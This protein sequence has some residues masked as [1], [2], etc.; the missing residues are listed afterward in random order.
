MNILIACDSFKDAAPALR[1]CEAIARGWQE[2]QPDA[3]LRLFPLADGGE[4][5]AD[6]LAYHLGLEPCQV[7]VHDPLM[8]P[9]EATYYV[10]ADGLLAFIEMAQAAGLQ[11]LLAHERNP[12][13][14]TTY[15]LGELIGHA[16]GRGARRLVLGL[17]GSATND[18]GM[19]MAV[20]LGWQFE[21]PDGEVLLPQGSQLGRVSG[22]IPPERSGWADISFEVMCDVT[23]PL[24]GPQGAA[25]VYGP[26]KGANEAEVALLDAG[27]AH[28]AEVCSQQPTA[29]DPHTAGA[30]AAGGLGFGA[31]FFLGARL[32]RGID[33]MLDRTHFDQ[34]LQWAQLVITGEGRLDSQTAQGKL[35]SG[36]AQRAARFQKPVIALCGALEADSEATRQLGLQAAFSIAQ[37][38]CSLEEALRATEENLEKTAFQLGRIWKG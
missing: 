3:E 7:W 11:R 21:G 6:A 15:G 36:I 23:N 25:Q 14:T 29:P 2:A 17:G 34:Q 32:Q 13:Y 9:V 1:V 28:F 20:A 19:G 18:A 4:G 12:L 24:F 38:P 30:G 16:I 31:L 33:V 5:M 8:R 26:Q 27:L 22:I 10:S 37:K 35:I